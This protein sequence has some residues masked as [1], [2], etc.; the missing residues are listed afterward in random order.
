MVCGLLGILTACTLLS[1]SCQRLLSYTV[2]YCPTVIATVNDSLADGYC[3]RLSPLVSRLSSLNSRLS[4]H[5]CV[6][7]AS[8]ESQPEHFLASPGQV[9][10]LKNRPPRLSHYARSHLWEG[11]TPKSKTTLTPSSKHTKL[12][13]AALPA[14]ILLRLGPE[15]RGHLLVVLRVGIPGAAIVTW[16]GR[17]CQIAGPPCNLLGLVFQQRGYSTLKALAPQPAP[18]AVAPSVAS[19]VASI[20]GAAATAAAGLR[21]TFC[22]STALLRASDARPA[23]R[24]FRH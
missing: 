17:P 11:R 22:G 14:P 20:V 5:A 10:R 16:Q 3:S 2:A 12:L 8:A 1:S 18:P 15:K 7:T 4:S 21:A 19:S 13:P 6:V 9:C 23:H 24:P